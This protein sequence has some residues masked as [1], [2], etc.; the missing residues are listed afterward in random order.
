MDKAVLRKPM[1]M[2]NWAYTVIRG[3]ILNN[4]LRVGEQIHI[5]LLIEKL[6]VSRT[7]IR[8]AL[9]R[10]RQNNL[11]DVVPHVGYFVSGITKK[12]FHDVF[13]LRGIIECYAARNAALHMSEEELDLCRE[14]VEKSEK[15]V[16][17]GK[18]EEYNECEIMFH[19]F[20]TDRTQNSRIHSVMDNV[21]DF[22]HRER[23][24]ALGSQENL[25]MSIRE[26]RAILEAIC[27][28]DAEGA[29]KAMAEHIT[30]V[31]KRLEGL[32]DF[33]DED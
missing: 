32:I 1:D 21:S 29:Y 20:L 26:H 19:S 25:Q 22:I 30:R 7:P 5:D 24:L 12:E 6:G 13:E 33:T 10:L 11:V 28:R 17:E 4:E 31:E 3:M 14:Y 16:A 23:V 9:L 2:N 18:Y 8:E 27:A 15:L